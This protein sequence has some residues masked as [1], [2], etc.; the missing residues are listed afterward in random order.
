MRSSFFFLSIAALAGCSPRP[1]STGGDAAAT[2]DAEM[3]RPGP[4][5][6]P[7]CGL[8]AAA[9]CDPFDAPK[10]GGG[11][12]GELDRTKWSVVRTEQAALG[13][14]FTTIGDHA[15]PIGTTTLPT[16]RADLP[17]KVVPDQDVLICDTTS[18][19][20]SNTLLMAAAEQ[21]Y[22]QVAARIRQPF[23]FASRTGK[24]VFDAALA[25]SGLLGWTALDVT[26]DPI[27]APSYLKVQNEENGPVPRNALEIHFDQNCQTDGQVSVNYIIVI[28]DYRHELIE[29]PA[30][31]RHCVAMKP[32]H[33]NHVEVDVSTSHVAVYASPASDDGVTF[34][35]VELLAEHDISLPFTSG[36]VQLGVFNH[37]SV[38]YSPAHDVDAY[39]A[40]FDNVG[41]DGPV[42][43][44]E[45]AAEVPDSLT[46]AAVPDG[47]V[48]TKAVNIGYKLG[49]LGTSGFSAP[50]SFT[51]ID[52]T[53]A[54]RAQIT[55]I[56]WSLL[57]SYN[58]GQGN[59]SDY[60]LDYRLNG[61]ATHAYHYTADQLAFMAA[62]LALPTP[63]PVGGSV[64]VRLDVDP[65]ELVSGVNTIQFA[66]KNVPTSYPPAVSNIDLLVSAP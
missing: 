3:P 42:L 36:Y 25:P 47:S 55:L 43:P 49:D 23:D 8:A 11:R 20:G 34:A 38:K 24:I 2:P 41:F 13:G 51:S 12:E 29:V 50:L 17:A 6:P 18:T 4:P 65:A 35:P 32:G 39:I 66:T 30:D 61:G 54:T 45:V 57:P 28:T 5:G 40:R 60:E 46:P 64:G 7:G 48:F 15:L 52:V 62:Q 19:L 27:G 14:D 33:L 56:W 58:G 9:F 44:V 1:A 10:A 59:A 53:G 37:A 26:E 16:C 22:G 21:N 63:Q 31:Q